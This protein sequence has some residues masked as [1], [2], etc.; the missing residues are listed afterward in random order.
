MRAGDPVT[1]MIARQTAAGAAATGKVLADFTIAATKDGVVTVLTPA[2]T[3]GATVGAWREYAVAIT[4]PASGPYFFHCRVEV[5][6]GADLIDGGVIDVEVEAQDFD[7]IYA[8][9]ATPVP[10]S[11]APVALGAERTLT[12]IAY[13]ENIVAQ[14]ITDQSG[15]VF[16]GSGYGNMRFT[17]WDAAHS[18][19]AGAF[20]TLSSGITFSAL[21]VLAFT[22][23]EDAAFYSQ[24]AAAIAA[25]LNQKTLYFDVIGDVSG[26]THTRPILRGQLSLLRY[27]GAA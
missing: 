2:V 5:A 24:I 10:L 4:L 1:F 21:G 16:D 3:E 15:G 17:V 18:G 8:L 9:V 22:V 27:E 26:A 11:T 20:Y 7:S 23:P 6:S 14:T 19:G 12:M 13:R 25:S